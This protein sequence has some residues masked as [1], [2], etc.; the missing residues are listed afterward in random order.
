[1]T[2]HQDPSRVVTVTILAFILSLGLALRAWHLDMTSLWLDEAHSIAQA[3]LWWKAIWVFN[4]SADVNPPLYF[5]ILKFW[6]RAFGHSEIAARSFSVLFG[7]IGIC[8]A[9]LLGRIAGGRLMGLTAAVLVAT[10]PVLVL[11]NRDTRGYSLAVA[12]ATLSLCGALT[13]L[14]R[15]GGREPAHWYAKPALAWPAYVGG[16]VVAAYTHTTLML[17]PVI[18]NFAFGL[19]WISASDRDRRT[20]VPWLIGNIV[21][22]VAYLPWLPN[23]AHGPVAAGSFWVPQVSWTHAL[24]IVRGVYGLAGLPRLQPWLDLG[25]MGLTIA[26][27]TGLRKNRAALILAVSVVVLVPLLTYLVSLYRPILILRVLIWPLPTLAL[28]VAAGV[29]RMPRPWIA[30]ALIGALVVLQLIG[31]DLAATRRNEP[32]RELTSQIRRERQPGDAIVIVPSFGAMAFEYYWSKDRDVVTV[33]L[34]GPARPNPL[35]SYEVIGPGDLAERLAVRRR[36]WLVVRHQPEEAG[37]RARD[38]GV[39]DVV[40]RLLR[41]MR[42]VSSHRY[43]EILDLYL[44]ARDQ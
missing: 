16:A 24:A 33:E 21:I 27:L 38:I 41:Q 22:L 34:I 9:F 19:V 29:L 15:A 25:V 11:Y 31:N 12:A 28:L 30:S 23:V 37:V 20:I 8:A 5:T 44:F 42:P 18:V 14:S 6:L 4:A 2:I 26:G 1:M 40:N 3:Q 39:E 13:L 32:W 7:V 36:F 17:L 43:S 10:S 35:W